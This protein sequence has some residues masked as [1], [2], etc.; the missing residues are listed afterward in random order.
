MERPLSSL[1]G[2]GTS[3]APHKP[4]NADEESGSAELNRSAIECATLIVCALCRLPDW[5]PRGIG[6][7]RETLSHACILA[8]CETRPRMGAYTSSSVHGLLVIFWKASKLT[9]RF[10][11]GIFLAHL[12][13]T[14]NNLRTFKL[15]CRATMSCAAIAKIDTIMQNSNNRSQRK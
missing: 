7:Q 10:P 12:E 9:S 11:P 3:C 6:Q 1:S 8:N 4:P 14:R 15:L 2:L 13:L 5:C